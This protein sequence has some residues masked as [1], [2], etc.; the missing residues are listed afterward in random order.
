MIRYN[1]GN[2]PVDKL[3][4]LFK[5]EHIKS[6]FYRNDFVPLRTESLISVLEETLRKL[7]DKIVEIPNTER[8]EGGET[9]RELN[10]SLEYHPRVRTIDDGERIRR[11]KFQLDQSAGK[12]GS[13][14]SSPYI[15][16]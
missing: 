16:Y 5:G 13:E 14:I 8:N 12:V 11:M 4:T 6:I 2:K 15:K 7:I 1:T 9:V 10:D 3:K